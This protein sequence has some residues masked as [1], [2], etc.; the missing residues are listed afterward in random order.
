V[1]AVTVN[2]VFPVSPTRE[3]LLGKV[4]GKMPFTVTAVT[5]LSDNENGQENNIAR[6]DAYLI[7]EHFQM[8][9]D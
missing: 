2:G 1:T 4:P 6:K 7:I 3:N 8:D 5:A 9:S